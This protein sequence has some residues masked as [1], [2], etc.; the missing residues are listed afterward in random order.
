MMTNINHL[1][2]LVKILEKEGSN[3]EQSLNWAITQ[4]INPFNAEEIA[5]IYMY[6]LESPFYKVLNKKMRKKEELDEKSKSFIFH[7]THILK[8]LPPFTGEVFR[9]IDCDVSYK[10]GDEICWAAFSSSTRDAK[11]AL[12]FMDQ[13]RYWNFFYYTIKIVSRNFSFLCR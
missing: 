13:K 7:T 2:L 11:V 5:L 12:K 3:G 10:E 1:L 8:K 6:T 9:G 4:P